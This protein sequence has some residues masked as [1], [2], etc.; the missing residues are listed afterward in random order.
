MTRSLQY[1]HLHINLPKA[2]RCK[3]RQPFVHPHILMNQT[4]FKISTPTIQLAR[5]ASLWSPKQ[6]I[7]R[8]EVERQSSYKW[9]TYCMIWSTNMS[10]ARIVR[11][12]AE[13]VSYKTKLPLGSSK[14]NLPEQVEFETRTWKNASEN[15]KEFMQSILTENVIAS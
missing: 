3:I 9:K 6:K 13:E 8:S 2:L 4:A 15:F 1:M 10:S 7:S 11:I 5:H 14:P 12:H